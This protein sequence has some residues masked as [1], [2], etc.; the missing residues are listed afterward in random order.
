MASPAHRLV[1]TSASRRALNS[2]DESGTSA[3]SDLVSLTS[4]RSN[5]SSQSGPIFTEDLGFQRHHPLNFPIPPSD[6]FVNLWETRM[7][8]AVMTTLVNDK[9]WASV[10]V[11]RRGHRRK[12]ED[13]AIVILVHFQYPTADDK[14]R[15][16]WE[17]I[18]RITETYNCSDDV[19]V[20]VCEGVLSRHA[21]QDDYNGLLSPGRSIG[22][23]G[24]EQSGTLGGFVKLIK[25][26]ADQG[27]YA[28]TCHHVV[29]DEDNKAEKE[30]FLHGKPISQSGPA[31]AYPSD[32]DHDSHTKLV[33]STVKFFE[34]EIAQLQSRLD[35]GYLT[36]KAQETLKSHQDILHRMNAQLDHCKDFERL[37]GL[38][39][40][41]SGFRVAKTGASLDWALVAVDKAKQWTNQYPKP[42]GEAFFPAFGQR[43]S[44][45]CT[46]MT[47]GDVGF[48]SGR[49]TK[50]TSGEFNAIKSNVRLPPSPLATRE[51]CF[52]GHD[53]NP[54]STKGDSGAWVLSLNGNLGGMLLGGHAEDESKP[55]YVTPIEAI[56]EDIKEQTGCEVELP[57]AS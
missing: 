31:I 30:F 3:E 10:D 26:G 29:V 41:S 38:V 22:R 4:I 16:Y 32:P 45:E 55:T 52:V 43:H 51:W 8:Q 36:D 56:F 20:E 25:D 2:S 6:P 1:K 14:L 54:F 40:C 34:K 39:Y 35:E 15:S 33:K 12:S 18:T 13:N 44:I 42:E 5:A 21:T 17:N 49:S 37:A 23:V 50:I 57:L 11:I 46:T 9:Q 47:I 19:K 28:M 48:K 53:A 7:E 24:L 27:I